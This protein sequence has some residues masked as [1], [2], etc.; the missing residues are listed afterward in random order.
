MGFSRAHGYHAASPG[1]FFSSLI[2][3]LVLV[4][5]LRGYECE[6]RDPEK[7]RTYMWRTTMAPNK[8]LTMTLRSKEKKEGMDENAMD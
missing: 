4:H 6:L 5:M 3:K 7:P 1:R 2:I 8:N